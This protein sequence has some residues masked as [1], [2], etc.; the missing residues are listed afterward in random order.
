MKILKFLKGA[1][2]SEAPDD[3]LSHGTLTNNRYLKLF[4]KLPQDFAEA[5][6][7]RFKARHGY[8]PDIENPKTFSEKLL[9]RI[10]KDRDPHYLI[11]GTKLNS[12]NFRP[13][14]IPDE[15]FF[16]DRLKVKEWLSP[17]DFQDLPE[18][19]VIKSSFGSGLNTV[20]R[21]K[22]TLDIDELCHTY[23]LEL[24]KK[25]NA[26][27]ISLPGNVAIFEAYLD[28]YGDYDT[29]NDYKFH[30]FQG[31]DGSSK[32]ILQIDTGRFEDHRQTMFDEEHTRLQFSIGGVPTHQVPPDLPQNINTMARVAKQLSSEFDYIRIDLYDIAGKVYFGEYTPFHQGGMGAFSDHKW[33]EY[34]G[35][36]WDFRLPTFQSPDGQ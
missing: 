11:Y 5:K 27:G 2:A 21:Q 28:D 20:V 9:T 29:P 6:I 10:L 12:P 18:R 34:L 30:C 25:V 31:R 24:P 15:L 26:Q 19:F 35:E 16:A 7:R 14:Q 8:L 1:V 4:D 33:D 36:L 32:I 3:E 23:N 22:V 13:E 17:G